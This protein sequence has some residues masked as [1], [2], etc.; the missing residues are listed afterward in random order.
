MDP[1]RRFAARFREAQLMEVQR[2]ASA[3]VA[4]V[5]LNEASFRSSIT[6]SLSRK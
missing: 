1:E 3:A 4:M 2:Q 6:C 5:E